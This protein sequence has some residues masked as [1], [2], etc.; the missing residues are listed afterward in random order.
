MSPT[1]LYQAFGI[2]GYRVVQ[3]VRE[4]KI[5]T[6][7]L[8]QDCQRDR[9]S[10]CQSDNVIRHGAVER[11]FRTVPLGG[12]PVDLCLPVPRLGCRD[13]GLIRQATIR[14]AKPLRRFTHAFERY[15]LNLLSHMTIQAVAEHLQVG[16]DAI[17][18]LFKRYLQTRFGK[19]KLKKLKR[20]AIDEISIGHGHR[21]LTIVLDLLS[22]AVVFI[23]KGKGANALIPLW[24]RIKKAHAK[25]EAAS[26]DMSPAYTLAVRT[27]LPNAIHVFDHFHIVKLFNERLSEFR[28]QLQNEAEGP[29]GKAVLKGTR[30]LILKNPENLNLEKGKG[31]YKNVNERERLDEALRI[32]QP[33]A[34]AYYMKE[35]FRLF[36]DQDNLTTAKR[37]LNDW[38][39]RAEVSNV[40][41]LMKMATTFQ[42]HRTG[43]LNYHRCPIS[44]GPLEGLNNK[45]KTLQRQAYGFRD[46][47]F[48]RLRIYSIHLAK[49]ALVG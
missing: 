37:F 7:H 40:S 23:G 5:I 24:K 39:R 15:A 30:W 38:C 46:Q 6:I 48:F 25:I 43:L 17:K 8:Q 3:T 44:S 22:G 34:T 47:E 28:R 45:I 12:K 49:Y 35:E 33:L 14:F 1:L 20:I 9:C 2:R 31:Q 10:N 16:W 29:L 11:T 32:N 41:V 19:P 42:L 4:E 21:Y 36:W 18:D 13:C 27:H 26:T